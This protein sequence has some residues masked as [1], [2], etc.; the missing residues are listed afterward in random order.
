[1]T[2]PLRIFTLS[3]DESYLMSL[4]QVPHQFY[5]LAPRAKKEALAE[6]LH[7]VSLDEAIQL[8]LDCVLLQDTEQP[9]QYFLYSTS[10]GYSPTRIIE[11]DIPA[12]NIDRDGFVHDWCDV[13]AEASNLGTGCRL[14]TNRPARKSAREAS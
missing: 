14:F 8:E 3:S 9:D 4:T 11:H 2:R 6:N 13:F 10:H 1:M 7:F 5:V 12:P